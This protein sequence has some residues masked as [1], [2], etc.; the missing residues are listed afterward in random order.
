MST[1]I[2]QTLEQS[3]QGVSNDVLTN[4]I[5]NDTLSL[6][7]DHELS[8]TGRG[9]NTLSWKPCQ[10]GSSK[11][12][13]LDHRYKRRCCSLIPAAADSLAHAH[14]QTTKTYYKH[15]DSRIKK[16]QELKTKTFAN[17][18]IKD[19]SLKTK[20]R[21]RLFE[22]FQEDAKYEH[23]GQDTRSH[24]GKDDKDKQGDKNDEI[25][26]NLDELNKS[27]L[28][29]DQD[30]W[31]PNDFIKPILFAA[32]TSKAEAQLPKLKEL[33][34]HLGYTFL[35]DNQEFSENA[36]WTVQCSGY[37]SEMHDD[38]LSRYVQRLY[39]SLHG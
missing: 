15:Q 32:S 30:G 38:S 19:P 21:G 37:I 33:P 20:L 22:S 1:K 26:H 35:N 9:S 27:R 34:S 25:E 31:E 2:K 39:G 24:D 13:L 28:S 6:L 11:L 12:N 16:A 3:Q 7:I 29:S 5:R 18:D 8:W 17:S 10:G 36:L 4:T 14:T 23:V